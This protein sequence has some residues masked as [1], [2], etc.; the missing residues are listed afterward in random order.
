MFI[1]F[2]SCFE[3]NRAFIRDGQRAVKDWHWW[4]INLQKGVLML[5]RNAHHGTF[6]YLTTLQTSF[7]LMISEFIRRYPD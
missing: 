4:C 7:D 1:L 3:G 2:G 6:Y 5:N